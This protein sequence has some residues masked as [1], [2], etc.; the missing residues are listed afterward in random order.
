MAL[1]YTPPLYERLDLIVLHLNEEQWDADGVQRGAST[2]NCKI[3][4]HF[5]IQN[6]H[7]SGEILHPFCIFSRKIRKHLAFILQFAVLSVPQNANSQAISQRYPWRFAVGIA[8]TYRV[9]AQ[10][11]GGEVLA[12]PTVGEQQLGNNSWGTTVGEQQL[13]NIVRDC[14][15]PWSSQ[16]GKPP[17]VPLPYQKMLSV[18]LLV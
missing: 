16:A 14:Q 2:S 3:S 7:F 4:G 6:H 11:G 17:V 12:V 18:S 8:G 13:G 1:S 9:L 15:S 10:R 5:S